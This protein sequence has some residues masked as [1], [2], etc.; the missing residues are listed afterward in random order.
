MRV[1][2]NVHHRE[3]KVCVTGVLPYATRR[4]GAP[5]CT[6]GLIKRVT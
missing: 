2:V 5:Q 6:Q 4:S 1:C 3:K